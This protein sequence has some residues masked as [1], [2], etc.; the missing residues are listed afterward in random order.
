MSTVNVHATC[1]VLGKFAAAFD[2]A[3]DTG[4]L[5]LGDS[6]AG[7]SDLALRLIARGAVLVADDRT[8]LSISDGALFASPPQTIVGLLE[9]RGAGIVRLPCQTHARIALA[10]MLV[11]PH[12]V[13]RLPQAEHFAPPAPL[14]LAEE[15]QPPLLR[16]AAFEESTPAKVA[17]AAAA[18]AQGRFV[19]EVNRL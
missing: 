10:V 15:F 14:V 17:L 6:G 9:V 1:V 19:K 2:A 13:P 5:L 3:S 18:F 7:K 4:V 8:D 11:P 16:L 12:A